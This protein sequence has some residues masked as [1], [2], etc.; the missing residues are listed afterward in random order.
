[1][2]EQY[3][4]T[5]FNQEERLRLEYQSKYFVVDASNS[6]ELKNITTITEL[7]RCLVATGRQ[8]EFEHD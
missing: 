2:V 5:D 4:P 1:M 6:E 7:C 8:S 3:Y